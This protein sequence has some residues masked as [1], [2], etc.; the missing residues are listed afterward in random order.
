MFRRATVGLAYAWLAMGASN[1]WSA[2]PEIDA[3]TLIGK[4]VGSEN[5]FTLDAEDTKYMEPV[6]MLVFTYQVRGGIDAWFR[7]IKTNPI[8]D[9]PEY[10]MARNAISLHHYCYAKV[11]LSRYYREKLFDL[12]TAHLLRTV[13]EF[14]FMVDHPEWLPENWPYLPLMYVELGRAYRIGNQLDLAIGAF[15]KALKIDRSYH[16]AYVALSSLMAGKGARDKALEYAAEGLRHNP[17]SKNLQNRYVGLGGKLPYPEPYEKDA[18]QPASATS[19]AE[20]NPAV[21][22][23]TEPAP[24][25]PGEPP[26]PGPASTSASTDPEKKTTP[27]CRFCP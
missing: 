22:P 4:H 12:R 25:M 7:L 18:R 21:T 15:T 2:D 11:S 26:I 1:A 24:S 16:D 23:T 9:R 5:G 19:T 8:P 27:H 17:S 13:H 3:K 10:A 20:S 14:N 6:C